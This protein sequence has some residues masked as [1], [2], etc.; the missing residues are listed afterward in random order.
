MPVLGLYRAIRVATAFA[1]LPDGDVI[2]GGFFTT[3]GG[4]SA[5]RIA[6]YNPATGVWSALGSGVEGATSAS[7]LALSVRQVGVVIVGG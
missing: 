2:V 7:V 4:I 6:R 1:V 5:N 3:A